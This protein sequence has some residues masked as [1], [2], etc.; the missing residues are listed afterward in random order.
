MPVAK[1]RISQKTMADRK[2]WRN[3]GIA[4]ADI[5]HLTIEIQDSWL[6]ERTNGREEETMEQEERQ[7]RRLTKKKD[8]EA[9]M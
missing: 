6:I 9:Y 5:S 8:K 1:I 7:R 2:L 3:N 4:D